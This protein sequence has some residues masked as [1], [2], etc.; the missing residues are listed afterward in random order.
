LGRVAKK[1]PGQKIAA[2]KKLRQKLPGA[3][4]KVIHLNPAT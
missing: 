3:V 4:V 2:A 1:V